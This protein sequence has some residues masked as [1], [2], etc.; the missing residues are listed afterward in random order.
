MVATEKMLALELIAN[1]SA[2]SL[3]DDNGRIW[4][5]GSVSRELLRE[6]GFAAQR[7]GFQVILIGTQSWEVS[8]LVS[9]D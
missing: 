4:A 1:G 6:A 5:T 9:L 2:K 3:I 8:R 7:D